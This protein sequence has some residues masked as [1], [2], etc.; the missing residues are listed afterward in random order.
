MVYV[1]GHK[2]VEGET[3]ENG[4]ILEHIEQDGIVVL[5]QGQRLRLPSDARWAAAR[6]PLVIGQLQHALQTFSVCSPMAAIE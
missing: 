5:Q 2:Y 3:L 6:F 1:N 4:A